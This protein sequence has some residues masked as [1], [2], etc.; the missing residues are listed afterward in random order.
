MIVKLFQFVNSLLVKTVLAAPSSTPVP[1]DQIQISAS[2]LGFTI[3]SFSVFLTFAIRGFFV[4]AGLLALMFLLLGAMAWVTSGGNKESVDKAR[5]KI[6][7][8]ILG[9]V[10]IVAVLAIMVTLEQVVFKGKLC[11]GISCD[12]VLPNLLQKSGP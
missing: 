12:L 1:T 5:D 3:P 10:I 11:F 9:V 6:T 2:E 7:A 4:L 8:A